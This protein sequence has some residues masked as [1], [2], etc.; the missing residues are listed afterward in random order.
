V[1][2][3]PLLAVSSDRRTACI[4]VDEIAGELVPTRGGDGAGQLRPV[5][6]SD[7]ALVRVTDLRKTFASGAGA[8]IALAGVTLYVEPGESVGLVGESGSGKTT[9]ARCVVGLE[10][11]D[12]GRIEVAGV[13]VTH[14]QQLSSV[15]RAAAR[16][17][18]QIVFQDPYSTLNPARSV[19]FTLREAL[20]RLPARIADDGAA[21]DE[22]LAVV[23]LPAAYGARKPAA[24]SGGERQRVAIARALALQPQVLVCDEPVSALDVSVQA[25]MLNL[26]AEL[27]RTLG[28]GYLFITHDLAV[29]RQVTERV[30]VLHRGEVVEDGPTERVLDAPTHPYTRSLIDSV[31]QSDPTW[32]APVSAPAAS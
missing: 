2:R 26:F 29:V 15:E 20:R 22:L 14:Q 17:V 8:H 24:L 13:D 23:G 10:R 31:P 4:R 25:Q 12:A 5:R 32:L 18:V 1:A 28:L 3:P 9:L 11:P 16:Q 6:A 19:R 21:V 27:R 7:G 30:Y